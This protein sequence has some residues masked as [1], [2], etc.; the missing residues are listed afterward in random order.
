MYKDK[1]IE[2]DNG[3]Q[4]YVLGELD[5]ANRRFI[6][7]MAVDV[8]KDEADD[9]NLVYKEIITEDGVD[10]FV[11]IEDEVE[12]HDFGALLLAKIREE[13]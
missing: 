2:L 4:I 12:A 5:F 3:L 9:E 13:E 6:A 7:G 11:A 8:D 10:K 1:I